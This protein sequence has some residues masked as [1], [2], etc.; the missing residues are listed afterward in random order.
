M[1]FN[2]YQQQASQGQTVQQLAGFQ[3]LPSSLPSSL[4]EPEFSPL[5]SCPAPRDLAHPF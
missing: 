5:L 2:L 1:I 4:L 3:T